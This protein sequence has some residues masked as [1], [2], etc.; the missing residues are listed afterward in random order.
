VMELLEGRTLE[1]ELDDSGPLAPARAVALLAPVCGAVAEAHRAG[2]L[3][4]D[5]K[6]ANIFLHRQSG[7]DVPKIVD[8][9]VA[10][11][12]G[13]VAF[14]RHLTLDSSLLGTPAYMAPERFRYEPYGPASDVYSLGMTLY[15][16]LA[17]RLPFETGGDDPLAVVAGQAGE[18]PPPLKSSN[19][20]VSD[21]LESAILAALSRDPAG[22]PTAAALEQRLRECALP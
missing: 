5:I 20:A 3:H 21:A 4:R 10:K 22:R 14:A 19:A 6:P 7:V 9:G 16:A 18:P 11:L 1:R 2:V 12:A 8:F 13:D 15:H 17:G